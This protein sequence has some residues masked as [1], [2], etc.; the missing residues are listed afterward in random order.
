MSS[1]ITIEQVWHNASVWV[2]PNKS[3]LV[4]IA[5][6]VSNLQVAEDDWKFTIECTNG[7]CYTISTRAV[8]ANCSEFDLVKRR[9]NSMSP[10]SGQAVADMTSLLFLNEPEMVNCIERRFATRQIYT[11]I[12]PILVA[13]NP[14]E[15]LPIYGGEIADKYFEASTLAESKALGPHV[16]YLSDSAYRRMF[17]D[18]YNPDRREDQVIL[19]NGESGSGKTES[20]KLVLEYLARVSSKVLIELD[21]PS[22]LRNDIERSIGAS[23]P[24]TESFGNAKTSR[25]N[26]S[27]RFGKIIDLLYSEDGYIEGANMC[28]Y[29]LETVRVAFQQKGERNYHGR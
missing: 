10:S 22:L 6:V 15:R 8:D 28:T 21:D 13:L 9:D 11:G 7:E 4:W 24:I 26:N 25:N 23:N 12:G 14:F 20:T 1:V 19:V 27:S 18:R 5:G 17:I 16:Y 2:L 29:L 3:S